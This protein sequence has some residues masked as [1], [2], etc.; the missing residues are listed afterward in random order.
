MQCFITIAGI[1]SGTPGSSDYCSMKAHGCEMK[2][3]GCQRD[4]D[5]NNNKETGMSKTCVDA[6]EEMLKENSWPDGTKYCK[7]G[8]RCSGMSIWYDLS[9]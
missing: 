8:Y 7:L 5:C 1:R 2:E 3:G 6:P 4:A 9:K